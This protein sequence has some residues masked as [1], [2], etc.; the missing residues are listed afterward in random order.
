MFAV[1]NVNVPLI[2]ASGAL[3]PSLLGA[4][5]LVFPLGFL[6]LHGLGRYAFGWEQRI[7]VTYSSGMKDLPIA[8]GLA[9][10]RF[11]GQ[12]LVGLPVAGDRV[13]AKAQAPQGGLRMSGRA[14]SRLV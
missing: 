10:S 14:K 12:P 4:V 11:Q 8:V 13:A 7:A 1:C 6:V 9:L 3:V 2:R 5:V